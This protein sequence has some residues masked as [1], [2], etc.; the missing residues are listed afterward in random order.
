MPFPKVDFRTS[1]RG[2][3]NEYRSKGNEVGLGI[4][5]QSNSGV[6]RVYIYLY[7]YTYTHRRSVF[8]LLHSQGTE[9]PFYALLNC[10]GQSLDLVWSL[11]VFCFWESRSEFIFCLPVDI[12]WM[13]CFA[14]KYHAQSMVRILLLLIFYFITHSK[15]RFLISFQIVKLVYW[16]R[17]AI[18]WVCFFVD[19]YDGMK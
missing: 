2:F 7:I 15:Y 6:S 10:A 14:S 16:I 4:D 18:C 13:F 1:R 12:F 8:D 3:K 11:V 19:V 17:H 5:M 9:N